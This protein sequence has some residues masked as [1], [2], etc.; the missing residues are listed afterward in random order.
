[1][2]SGSRNLAIQHMGN[3]GLVGMIAPDLVRRATRQTKRMRGREVQRCGMY[4]EWFP[5]VNEFIRG[6]QEAD[7]E[8]LI[9]VDSNCTTIRESLGMINQSYLT[10]YADKLADGM[11]A[12]FAWLDTM[13][14]ELQTALMRGIAQATR[15][16][17]LVR[18]DWIEHKKWSLA[19]SEPGNGIALAMLRGPA[20]KGTE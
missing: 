13:P 7:P 18:F 20:P 16:E 5:T 11:A 15:D 10:V 2:G 8:L 12:M 4:Y 19:W 9:M 17:K 14:V 1:M 6:L 3:I